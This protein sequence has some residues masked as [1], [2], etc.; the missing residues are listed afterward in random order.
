LLSKLK[1]NGKLALKT[2]EDFGESP[3]HR[4]EGW[5]GGGEEGKMSSI[6]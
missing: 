3:L 4:E 6:L 5:G 2:P 1:Q